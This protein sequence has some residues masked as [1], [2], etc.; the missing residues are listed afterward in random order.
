MM[1]RALQSLGTAA[2]KYSLRD[3]FGL[4]RCLKQSASGYHRE[5]S[6]RQ[7]NVLL[8][9]LTDVGVCGISCILMDQFWTSLLIELHYFDPR[10]PLLRTDSKLRAKTCLS[11]LDFP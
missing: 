10:T 7:Q 4:K 5:V 6:E 11:V 1:A 8:Y 9:T 2:E 3:M